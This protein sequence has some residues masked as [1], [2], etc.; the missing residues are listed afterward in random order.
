M[1]QPC[2][3]VDV[4]VCTFRRP[5]VVETLASLAVQHLPPDVSLRVVVADNDELPSAEPQVRRAARDLGLDLAYIHAPARNISIARN[6]CLDAVRAD[7][8]AMIDDDETAD[9]GWLAALLRRAEET[10]ADVV[11]GPVLAE[12]GPEAP[13]WMRRL[14][15]HS[16]HPERRG[17]VVETGHAG[18]ALLR[19]GGAPW[20]EER[21]DLGRGRS[22][23]EDTEYFFRL[24]RA[25]ALFE[26][27]GD[28]VIRE[29]VPAGRL[30]FGWL[31]RRRYRMGQSHAASATAATARARLAATAA[32]K[33]GI[34]GL[35]ACVTLPSATRRNLW[36][37][38]M[39]LH[40]GVVAGC[41]SVPQPELYGG[42]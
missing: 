26:I 12:Y 22:G 11:F 39:G 1:T 7:F 40:A 25:G 13:D 20:R 8:A 19:L 31:L 30:R 9:P 21:F 24:R 37:L 4:L 15:Y 36:T 33:A 32:A 38:R 5:Q 35:A 41:L 3:Q 29:P 23:G 34:C 28:A 16:S 2:R 6:A 27:A 17:G 14:G 18:N 10:G 42:D